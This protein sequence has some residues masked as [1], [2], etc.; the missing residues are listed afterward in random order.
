MRDCVWLQPAGFVGGGQVC[1]KALTLD[2]LLTHGADANS[3]GWVE[4]D[5]GGREDGAL[6]I[7]IALMFEVRK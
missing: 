6:P 1:A 4:N 7:F 5:D 2:S 3:R